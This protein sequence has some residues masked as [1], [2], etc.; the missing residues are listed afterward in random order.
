MTLQHSKR[1]I[2]ND[3]VNYTGD[4]DTVLVH[5]DNKTN[6]KTNASRIYTIKGN[7]RKGIFIKY[8]KGPVGCIQSEWI[9]KYLK[10][11]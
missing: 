7:F 2:A 1:A 5:K 9:W 4:Q 8:K 6:V 10:Y 3:K 11:Y